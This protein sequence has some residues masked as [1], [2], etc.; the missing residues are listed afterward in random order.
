MLGLDNW[1]GRLDEIYDVVAK[2]LETMHRILETSRK[3]AKRRKTTT[4]KTEKSKA[5]A[6][7]KWFES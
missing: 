6:L 5:E 2:E 3:P 1:K 7:T 4:E